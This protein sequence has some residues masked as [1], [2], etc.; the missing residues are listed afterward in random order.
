MRVFFSWQKRRGGSKLGDAYEMG[1]VFRCDAIAWT[2]RKHKGSKEFQIGFTD[3]S[4]GTTVIPEGVAFLK[5]FPGT[6]SPKDPI[7]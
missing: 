5:A 3:E 7:S 4:W 2:R 6:L 1:P